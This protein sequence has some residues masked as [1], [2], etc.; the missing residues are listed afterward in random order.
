M[1]IYT[2]FLFYFLQKGGILY[3]HMLHCLLFPFRMSW[4]EPSASSQPRLC[5]YSRSH[6]SQRVLRAP[7]LCPRLETAANAANMNC[8]GGSR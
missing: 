2:G 5:S 4:S 6:A 8:A 3:T 1:Y 7:T